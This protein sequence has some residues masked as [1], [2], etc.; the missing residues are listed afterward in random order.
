MANVVVVKASPSESTLAGGAPPQRSRD[1]FELFGLPAQFPIDA[2]DLAVRFR[3]LQIRFHP[4]KFVAA[5][6]V[7]Q[8]VAAQ[9]SADINA[10][11]RV[12][13]NPVSRA[14]FMLERVGM[15]LESV[16]RQPMPGDFLLQQM[17]LREAAAQL[18][19]G[20]NGQRQTLERQVQALYQ[21]HID[22][23]QVALEAADFDKAGAVWQRLLFV[24]KLRQ[25]LELHIA[26][27]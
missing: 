18:A 9:I 3:K 27:H 12:L 13:S 15:N 6:A 4:D 16:E 21:E 2:D 20:D 23:F 10:G 26:Q 25:E 22:G 24:D 8:R 5:G 11:Y 7:E 1:Y 17:E 19:Q 14:R